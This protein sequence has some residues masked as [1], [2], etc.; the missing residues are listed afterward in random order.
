MG[1]LIPLSHHYK[2]PQIRLFPAKDEGE[3]VFEGAGV[4]EMEYDEALERPLGREGIYDRDL[5]R[6]S[7]SL[8]LHT[9]SP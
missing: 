1:E 8:D 4:G 3:V 6:A 9:P 2:P 7:S 5:R